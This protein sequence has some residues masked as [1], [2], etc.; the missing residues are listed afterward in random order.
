MRRHGYP[1]F[2]DP[3]ATVPN[4]RSLTLGQGM[5]FP[6]NS[7]IDFQTPPPAFVHAIRACG[8]QF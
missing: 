8:V 2:P 5:Y 3:L 1:Q 4:Q 6:I 7:T